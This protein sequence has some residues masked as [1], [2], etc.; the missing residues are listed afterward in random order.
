MS[1]EAVTPAAPEA[2]A[3]PAGSGPQPDTSSEPAAATEPATHVQEATETKVSWF[4]ALPED[5]KNS[6]GV[7]KH[8][9]GGLE[10]FVRSALNN[11]SLR[12][13]S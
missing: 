2:T 6:P 8:H 5:L 11:E 1:D 10:Q 4:D 7:A 9:S 12:G 3:E 13:R